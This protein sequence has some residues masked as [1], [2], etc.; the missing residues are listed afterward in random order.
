MDTAIEA[1]YEELVPAAGEWDAWDNFVDLAGGVDEDAELDTNWGAGADWARIAKAERDAKRRAKLRAE[2]LAGGGGGAVPEQRR[3]HFGGL[4]DGS[5]PDSLNQ[6]GWWSDE[7]EEEEDDA[8][9]DAEVEKLMDELDGLRLGERA[10][11]ANLEEYRL[12]K[13]LEEYEEEEVG[14]LEPETVAGDKS[15]AVF[16]SVMDEYLADRKAQKKFWAEELLPLK[17]GGGAGVEEKE[18]CESNDGESSDGDS[19]DEFATPTKNSPAEDAV[20]ITGKK[21]TA[22]IKPTKEEILR[23]VERQDMSPEF[24]EDAEIDRDVY[25]AKLL[26]LMGIECKEKEKWD[27]ETIL[28]T[29]SNL[30][31]HPGRIEVSSRRKKRAIV[32]S[33]ETD[34][35][36]AILE[37]DD[38]SGSDEEGSEAPSDAEDSEGDVLIEAPVG[39]RPKNETKEEKKARKNAVKAARKQCREMKKANTKL[40]KEEAV[41]AKKLKMQGG[42]ADVKQGVRLFAL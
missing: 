42:V 7:E 1:G 14:Q 26:K 36:G 27:C 33:G 2:F 39:P 38:E 24:D 10:K 22:Y 35:L 13:M 4:H 25:D 9:S 11:A 5:S 37:G 21:R 41:K 6:A 15:L 34:A 32:R 23:Q 29:Q 31:N 18:A 17:V 12:A 8:V 19:N 30:S 3:V 28:S 20:P 16:D 40:F